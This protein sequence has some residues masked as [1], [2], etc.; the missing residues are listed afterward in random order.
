MRSDLTI[1]EER[2]GRVRVIDELSGRIYRLRREALLRDPPQ[3]LRR[4]RNPAAA[5]SWLRLLCPRIRLLNAD[6]IAAVLGGRTG[7]FFSS[8]AVTGWLVAALPT[9]VW[10]SA[11]AS[12]IVGDALGRTSVSTSAATVQPAVVG[13]VVLAMM[14]TLHELGHAIVCRRLGC[15][16]GDIGIIAM[17]GFPLA[18]C[19]VNDSNRLRS[20]KLRI[21]VMTG[22]IYAELI[23]AVIA[24][25]VYAIACYMHVHEPMVRQIAAQIVLAGTVSTV[26]WNANPLMR[27]DGY[28][29]LSDLLDCVNLRRESQTIFDRRRWPKSHRDRMLFLYHPISRLYR[30]AIY[31]GLMAM[32]FAA[33]SKIGLSWPVAL[34]G[35]VA[36]VVIAWGRLKRTF[37]SSRRVVAGTIIIA[38]LSLGGL[39]PVP[40]SVVCDG[41]IRPLAG[42]NIYVPFDAFVD[43]IAVTHG[44]VVRRGDQLMTL[45]SDPMMRQMR[46]LETSLATASARDRS[47]TRKMI[48]QTDEPSDASILADR[49]ESLR[50]QIDR[51]DRRI[52]RGT[53]IADQSGYYIEWSPQRFDQ[54]SQT[55]DH[56]V[57]DRIRPESPV[58]GGET[59]GMVVG[60]HQIGV[61]ARIVEND[62]ADLTIGGDA[63]VWIGG[64]MISATVLEAVPI[65]SN[66][67]GPIDGYRVECQLCPLPAKWR[68]GG[69]VD[70]VDDLAWVKIRLPKRP[71]YAIVRQWFAAR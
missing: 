67:S 54:A 12:A 26:F 25:W 9:A 53:I 57:L 28:F 38:A 11:N 41:H 68:R 20:P 1:V 43:S 64:E 65:R 19:D 34:L 70:R 51:L 45:R 60:D 13:L 44:D 33:A 58:R 24:T 61:I 50:K 55:I 36:I 22:G 27:H 66:A 4:Q 63:E 2:R 69:W 52:K 39:V 15:K 37:R 14:K 17:F 31:G 6:R 16:V 47:M 5:K 42:K 29:V 48:D 32:V 8:T 40:R 10:L 3:E 30:M 49:T 46:T 62:R 23:A 56:P 59:V 71:I 21:A 18:Y 35:V 7:I